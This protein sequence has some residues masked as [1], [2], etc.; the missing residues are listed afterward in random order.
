MIKEF[1]QYQKQTK[2][3]FVERAHSPA[4]RQSAKEEAARR[5]TAAK[6]IDKNGNL[7]KQYR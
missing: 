1:K 4:G 3:S 6:I 2:N 5:L 7:A